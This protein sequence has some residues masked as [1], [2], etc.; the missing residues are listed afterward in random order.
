MTEY[1]DYTYH[2]TSED[3]SHS[4]LKGPLLAMLGEEKRM[5][6]DIGCGN[7]SL[8]IYLN[9]NG[10]D[11]YGI[12]PSE[13]GIE[14]AKRVLP[15]KFEVQDLESNDLPEA[16]S[17]IVFDTIISTEVVEH[18]YD[19]VQYIG[20]C[21]RIL[22]RSHKGEIILSTPY[23]G[24]LKNLLISVSGKWDAHADP[25]WKGGHIKFWSI[26]TLSKLLT[27][28]GFEVIQVQ[29]CGRI[30]YLWKSMMIK[31]RLKKS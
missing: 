20:F 28:N 4:Y 5:I 27:D 30:P 17:K 22:Q 7:G 24:Y 10:F 11:V 14:M 13:T 12:D 18:L 3:H 6:L 26:K 23:H 15:H 16:F 29:G 19:P 8:S 9:E 31:A 1:S 25:F 2:S 21:K